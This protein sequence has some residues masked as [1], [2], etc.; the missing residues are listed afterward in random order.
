[1][2]RKELKNSDIRKRIKTHLAEGASRAD[3]F[4]ELG[5][6]DDVAREV[7]SVPDCE[8]MEKYKKANYFL[9]AAVLYLGIL[10]LLASWARYT[11]GAPTYSF[12]LVLF[13]PSVALFF[14][15]QIRRYHGGFYFIGACLLAASSLN[16][17]RQL[18]T[19]MIDAK[20]IILWVI[21]YLP[22][23]AGAVLGFFLKKKL[24][25]DLGYLGAKV[26]SSGKYHF[27]KDH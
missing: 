2:Q 20:A 23:A 25:P 27:L 22:V 21:M 10:K 17:T 8:A 24:F 5:G 19:V 3:V 13:V 11:E 15:I 1:M 16:A 12:P 4:R 6:T 26:D 14:A 18:E 9:A 7:A